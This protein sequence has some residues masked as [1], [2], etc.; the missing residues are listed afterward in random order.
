M[1]HVVDRVDGVLEEKLEPRG[2]AHLVA[3]AQPQ[4]DVRE[5]AEREPLRDHD[6]NIER[7]ESQLI[8]SSGRST[9][10]YSRE[11]HRESLAGSGS[12]L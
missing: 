5:H 1:D 11:T 10:V 8:D 9:N 12:A 6:K 3:V 4:G 7:V 2:L